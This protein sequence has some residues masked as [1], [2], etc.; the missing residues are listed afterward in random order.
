[1]TEPRWRTD[2]ARPY[3]VPLSSD[4]LPAAVVA[5]LDPA[6]RP[7]VLWGDWFGGGVVVVR[8]PLHRHETPTA[9]E[10]SALLDEQPVLAEMPADLVGGG[11]LTV[12]G[13]SPG[14]TIAAYHD[15]LLRWDEVQGW[16]F[17]SLGLVG[18]EAADAEALA[19]WRDLLADPP[20]LRTPP[21]L[22]FSTRAGP[23][24]T[25]TD[26]LG[27]VDEVIGR[28][29]RGD[30][31]QLNLCLRLHTTLSEAVPALFARVAAAL[32]PAYAALVSGPG[33]RMVASF[34]PELF[35]RVRGRRVT[36]SPIKGT[37]PR[38]PTGA[39]MLRAS[40]KDAAENVMIVDLM[41][42]D[43]SRVCRPGTVTVD[44]LLDVQ[45]HSGVWHL[46]STVHGELTDGVGTADLLSATFP[47]GSV[48]GAP[49]RA[50]EQAIAALEA[51]PRG[52]YTGSLGLVSP[53]GTDLSVLI[54][55]FETDGGRLQLGVGGGI[56]ADSVPIRE[57]YECL[58]K[59][60]PLVAAV[61]GRLAPALAGEPGPPEANLLAAGV[62]ETVLVRHGEPV[63]L[64][65]H[66][67]RLD[68]SI[69]ELYG[70][71]LP[72]D[73]PARVGTHLAEVDRVPRRALRI[74]VRPLQT[75]L[76][77]DVRTRPLGPRLTS[78]A[79]VL[80]AR[81]DRSWRHK[82]TDRVGLEQAAQRTAPAIPYFTAAG[83]VTETDR[84]NLFWLDASGR[85][86]TPPLDEHALPGVT[87]REV[88]D[89][90]AEGGTPVAVCR[91]TPH[92]LR[93]A[94]GAFWT[95]SLSGAVAVTAVDGT[96]LPDQSAYT[97]DLSVRLG[98]N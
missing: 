73:L 19:Y 75:E 46:V 57:W 98:V 32:R 56:T 13:Y 49:K 67:A 12:L 79:V 95:S 37:A 27:T 15:S 94:A 5:T 82:W 31:Y 36:T 93:R 81:P 65:G 80:A 4:A 42:N 69:R 72:T 48:T 11:W 64:A 51:E 26:Y 18:R 24:T 55:T 17:E 43:L 66:L 53:A 9:A 2:R 58:H 41:R 77:V 16:R 87:R 3:R 97:A 70:S 14:S 54:R 6:D 28:I 90:L 34:S 1:M 74:A 23:E 60:A 71:G 33:M 38:T 25:R 62:F 30:F 47:P 10:A 76:T 86:C 61:G 78:S 44:E 91:T 22:V 40:A 92:E 68:R 59:A 50:A 8:R 84:G 35:L 83:S 20:S 52:A 39:A 96:P 7:G 89:L 88:L 45:P 63:R 21:G 29:H 85:W